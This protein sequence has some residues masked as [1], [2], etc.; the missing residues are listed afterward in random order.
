M[1]EEVPDGDAVLLAPRELRQVVLHARV[2]R[3]PALVVED[4]RRGGEAMTLV[5]EARS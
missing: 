4:H 3:E 1:R 5:S 2:E